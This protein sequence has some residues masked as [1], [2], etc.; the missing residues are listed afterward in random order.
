MAN[1]PEVNPRTKR[2]LAPASRRH[3]ALVISPVMHLAVYPGK[4]GQASPTPKGWLPS[5]PPR[6]AKDVC[7]RARMPSCSPVGL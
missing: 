4:W 2:P 5:L 1:L 7:T 3:V 6:K